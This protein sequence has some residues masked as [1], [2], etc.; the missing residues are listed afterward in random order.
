MIS[1]NLWN[2]GEDRS[3]QALPITSCFSSRKQ[4]GWC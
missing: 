1:G 2:T 3:R 4:T